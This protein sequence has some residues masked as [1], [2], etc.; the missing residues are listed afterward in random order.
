[1]E[2][3][4]HGF[5]LALTGAL[6]QY[7]INGG[8]IPRFQRC[9]DSVP[10]DVLFDMVLRIQGGNGST[11]LHEAA[12][13]GDATF[14]QNICRKLGSHEERFILIANADRF[15]Q[16]PL[17]KA[18]AKGNT[19]AAGMLLELL[20]LNKR[21]EV[22][23]KKDENQCTAISLAVQGNKSEVVS[24]LE[25]NMSSHDIF[26]LVMDKDGAQPSLIQLAKRL[27]HSNVEDNLLAC[28]SADDRQHL[29]TTDEMEGKIY[30]CIKQIFAKQTDI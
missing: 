24:C 16:T 26:Q 23:Q 28:L 7:L 17:H 18:F 25:G 11:V 3:C 9:L 5:P 10:S 22:L 21:A 15:G 8:P 2:T 19:S 6:E 4:K 29:H 30:Y 1:M 12:W 27:E 13:N 20:P 14:I